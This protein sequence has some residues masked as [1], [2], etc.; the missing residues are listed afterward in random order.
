MCIMLNE[1]SVFSEGTFSVS[2]AV[3][4]SPAYGHTVISRTLSQKVSGRYG[5]VRS[6]VVVCGHV[7]FSHARTEPVL[8][9]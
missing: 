8:F 2:E 7:S 3:G 6:C 4:F 5:H 1:S 9:F